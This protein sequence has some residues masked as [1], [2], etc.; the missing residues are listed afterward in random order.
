MYVCVCERERDRDRQTF[1]Q[2]DSQSGRQTDI[3]IDRDTGICMQIQREKCIK[4]DVRKQVYWSNLRNERVKILFE[5]VFMEYENSIA[6]GLYKIKV[7]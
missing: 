5:N 4:A 7:L 1:R 6:L 3:E 2:T